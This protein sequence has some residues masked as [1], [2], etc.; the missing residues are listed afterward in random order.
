MYTIGHRCSYIYHSLR[1]VF[2]CRH[3]NWHHDAFGSFSY[4]ELDCANFYNLFS[5]HFHP[6]PN[7]RPPCHSDPRLSAK[8]NRLKAA[9]RHG[10]QGEANLYTITSGMCF[11][12][13]A[14]DLWTDISR[15]VV[16]RELLSI[17]YFFPLIPWKPASNLHKVLG[18]QEAFMAYTKGWAAWSLAAHLG[19]LVFN[20]LSV[21][22]S[23]KK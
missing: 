16:L 6:A 14:R 2:T 11:F 1:I 10:G 23:N 13:C 5:V 4:L 9:R 18:A 8:S 7:L 3:G 21:D 12:L 15:P 17:F 20:F 22:Q 19:V